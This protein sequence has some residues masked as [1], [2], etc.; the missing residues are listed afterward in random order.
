MEIWKDING[1]EN[2]YQVSNLGNVKSL[3]R[4][5]NGVLGSKRKIKGRLL[6]PNIGTN[7]YR[8]VVLTNMKT[9]Y[10]HRLVADNFIENPQKLSDVDHIDENKLNNKLNNLRFLSH[11]DNSSRSNKGRKRDLNLSKNPKA[12]KV[13]CYE[14]EKLQRVYDCAKQI[15]LDFKIDYSKVKY[16]LQ[17]NKLIINNLKFS[18]YEY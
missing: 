1:F 17:K 8:Y 12:K 18:Y 7:G 3:E 11:F 2:E 15:S 14:N 13:Y 16:G 5:V 10:I 4:F 9:K 6:K